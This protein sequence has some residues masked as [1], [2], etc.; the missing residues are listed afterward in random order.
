MCSMMQRQHAQ[1]LEAQID[2]QAQAARR[3]QHGLDQLSLNV[4]ST[5]A[6]NCDKSV[7]A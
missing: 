6:R 4:W 5:K 3:A 7:F 2:R 1:L